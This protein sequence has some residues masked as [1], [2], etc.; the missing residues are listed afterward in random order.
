MENN[1]KVKVIYGQ[2][3]GKVGVVTGVFW[4]ANTALIK[5]DNGEEIAVKPINIITLTD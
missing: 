3:K 4:G 2:H 5:T 1:Q